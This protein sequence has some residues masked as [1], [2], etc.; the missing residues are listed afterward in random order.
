MDYATP[1]VEIKFFV[2]PVIFGADENY[3]AV[4][5]LQLRVFQV[6]YVPYLIQVLVEAFLF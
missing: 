4:H 2:W 3:I 6:Q 1:G 5:L